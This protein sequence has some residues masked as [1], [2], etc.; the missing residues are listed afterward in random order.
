M[1]GIGSGAAQNLPHVI[2]AGLA[3]VDS[4]VGGQV[5][6]DKGQTGSVTHDTRQ[7]NAALVVVD[8]GNA[9]IFRLD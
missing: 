2:V 5:G 6:R 9:R 1:F 8:T 3:L 7:D 4:L